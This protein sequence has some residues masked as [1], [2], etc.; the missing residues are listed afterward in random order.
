MKKK[1]VVI[2]SVFLIIFTLLNKR[3]EK[4][5]KLEVSFLQSV[6]TTFIN[7]QDNLFPTE[8]VPTI[9]SPSKIDFNKLTQVNTKSLPKKGY[10][11]VDFL[12]TVWYSTVDSPMGY[13][14]NLNI[15]SFTVPKGN[16]KSFNIYG[17]ILKQ[18]LEIKLLETIDVEKSIKGKIFIDISKYDYPNFLI[19]SVDNF[20]FES[21]PAGYNY[22]GIE[23][24][25]R[26]NCSVYFNMVSKYIKK[27][28][29]Y[30][31][32]VFTLTK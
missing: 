6:V 14:N 7:N 22:K 12:G 23:Y 15:I 9:Y 2:L 8:Q 29:M 25:K 17:V 16:V 19:S 5:I 20:D 31:A 18:K 4:D 24:R 11:W 21:A 1:L 28:W 32:I 13:E 30:K 27:N 26:N 10:F 3:D